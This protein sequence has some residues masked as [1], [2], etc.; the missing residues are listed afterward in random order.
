[1]YVFA[2]DCKYTFDSGCRTNT[3]SL[4]LVPQFSWQSPCHS[5]VFKVNVLFT[6]PVAV[7]VR[8]KCRP[9]VYRDNTSL[10]YAAV[11]TFQP[12][13]LSIQHTASK[14][15]YWL[16][17][18]EPSVRGW[19]WCRFILALTSPDQRAVAFPTMF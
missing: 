5:F 9:C 1:V 13:W 11:S 10:H 14:C 17:C 7:D 4:C 3:T 2:D 6:V 15:V 8:Y 12:R 18:P 16:L 19:H